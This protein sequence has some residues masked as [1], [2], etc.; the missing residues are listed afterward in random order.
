MI[1]L[2][3]F[4]HLVCNPETPIREALDRI[5]SASPHLFQV[6]VG[7]DG[8]VLGTVTDGDVR[9]AML[10]G[11]TIDDAVGQ[12]MHDSPII[13]RAGDDEGNRAKLSAALFLPVVDVAGRVQHILVQ[14]PKGQ[15]IRQAL[16]MAGGYGNRLGERTRDIP[17]PLLPVG[18]RP[19]LEH[20]LRH[21]ED[22]GISEIHIAV[23]YLAEKIQAFVAARRNRARIDLIH[24]PE[25][26]GTAGALGHFPG[27]IEG[28]I[29]VVN[30]DVVTRADIKALSEFH[31]DRGYDGT[32]AVTRYDVRVPFGVLRHN[33]DGLFAGI[34]EKPTFHHFVA[35]GIYC[36][37]P[38]FVALV[39]R[40]RPVDMPE[41]LE[42]GHRA[43][44]RIG[45]FPV[46]EY[47]I[48]VGEP[49]DLEAAESVLA[50]EG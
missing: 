38:D 41:V 21:L 9:R 35:A 11:I 18:D 37:S 49:A 19:I 1:R 17:K 47:W 44:L 10:C 32:I 48:D 13:G 43:G 12:C 23:H 4:S 36:L 15:I 42:I 28:P 14:Y 22:A 8:R 6:V 30:G 24:E 50:D 26:L 29:L 45:L 40:D 20:V 31:L 2:E 5:N 27:P 16:V 3:Q 25:P 34:D 46:H 33:K 39:P 7:N